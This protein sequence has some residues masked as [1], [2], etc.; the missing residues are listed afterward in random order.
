MAFGYLV[1]GVG[2]YAVLG[3]LVDRWLGTE[4]WLPVGIVAGTALGLYLTFARFGRS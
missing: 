2:L 3:W 4:F 1:A